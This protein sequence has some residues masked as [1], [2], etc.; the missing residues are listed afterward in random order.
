MQIDRLNM[1]DTLRESENREGWREL[2]TRTAHMPI[3]SA[4]GGLVV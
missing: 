1:S 3:R 4:S 2:V